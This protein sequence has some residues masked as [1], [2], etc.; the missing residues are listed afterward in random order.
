[1]KVIHETHQTFAWSRPRHAREQKATSHF[2]L[3]QGGL[4]EFQKEK[5][6]TFVAV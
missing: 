4:L 3:S 2:L 6:R 5:Q 1:M